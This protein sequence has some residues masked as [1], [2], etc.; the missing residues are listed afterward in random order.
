MYSNRLDF[1]VE[2]MWLHSSYWTNEAV[3]FKKRSTFEPYGGLLAIW[4]KECWQE[5][6]SHCGSR[7]NYK[8]YGWTIRDDKLMGLNCCNRF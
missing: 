8:K 5:Q 2:L 4:R 6:C 7:I 1:V 3:L